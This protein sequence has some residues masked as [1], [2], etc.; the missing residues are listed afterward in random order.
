MGND[1]EPRPYLDL[2]VGNV[3][4]LFQG[5]RN[6]VSELT[7]LAQALVELDEDQVKELL[8]QELDKGTDPLNIIQQCNAAM[9]KIGELFEDNEYYLSELIMSGEIMKDVTAV[10]EPLLG[11]SGQ[12]NASSKGT[13]IIGTVKDD[14]HDIGKNIVATLLKG[15]GFKVIDLGVDVPAATFIQTLKE[16]GAKVLGLSTL[17]NFTFPQMKN[18]IEELH[19]AGMRDSVKVIIG[20]APCNEDVRKFVG[21]DY[22]AKDAA[23]GVSACK[24]IYA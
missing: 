6:E 2:A 20:G 3:S 16:T 21:A 7:A 12:A 4:K 5:G 1:Q 23:A 19:K 9:S 18:V 13:I 8:Q 17:L 10:L 24:E 15:T 22:Y 11:D 14:I